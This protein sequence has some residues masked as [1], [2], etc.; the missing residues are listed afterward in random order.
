MKKIIYT[1][2]FFLIN[3]TIIKSQTLTSTYPFPDYA[4][5]NSFWGITKINDTLRIATDNNGSIYKVTTAG[6]IR[7]SLTT[8]FTFNHGLV[9][10]GTGYWIA[11]DFRSAGARLLK[12]NSAGIRI[13]SIQLP[14]LIGGATGGVGDIALDASGNGIWFSV[15]SPDFT[16]YPFAY[17]YKINLTSRIITDTIPLRG[18]QVQGITVKGD[19][20]LYVSDSFQGDAERIYAYRKAVGDTLF[21]FPVPDPDGVCKPRGMHW[22]GQN[23]WLVADRIG[24]NMFIYKALYKYSLTGLGNPQITTNVNSLDFGNT[25]IG[26]S[27]DRTLTISNTGTAKLIIS[28][29]NITNPRFT[30]LP[31]NVPDTINIGQTKNYTVT[32]APTVFDTTSGQL[33]IT[34]NDGGT[35]VKIISLKGKGVNNGSN[36]LLSA[37]SYDFGDRNSRSTCGWIFSITNT[38]SQILNIHLMETYTNVFKIDTVGLTFPV[39]IDTQKTKEFRIWFRPPHSASTTNIDSLRIFSNAVNLPIAK[40]YLAGNGLLNFNILFGN[41]VWQGTI[42]DNPFTSSDYYKPVSIKQM[43]DINGDQVNEIV[44]AS[45]NYLTTCFNG[46]SSV[47]SDVLWSFNTGTSN[48]NSGSVTYED[49]MQIRSDIDGDGFQDV[50]IGCG[51]GNEMVYT[52]SGRTGK[53]IWA[54]GDSVTFSDGDVNGVRADKDYNNDGIA[55]VIF[56]ASGESSGM[57]RRS[58]ICV[59]GLNGNLIFNSPQSSLFL[60]DV[61]NTQIGGAISHSNSGAPYYAQGFNNTGNNLWQYSS[62]DIIWGMRNIPS[63]NSDTINEIICQAG[64]SGRVTAL[65]GLTGT[66]I[67]ERTLGASINGNVKYFPTTQIFGNHIDKFMIVSGQKTLNKL[68]P[69][70]GS[71]MWTN[72]L[73]N[74]Y[75]LGSDV[76]GYSNNA[77]NFDVAAGTLGNNFYILNGNTG[78]V[79]FQYSFG[80]G[81]TN[82]AVEKV[83]ILG[84]A[85]SYN[86]NANEIVAGSRDGRIICFTGGYYLTPAVTNISTNIPHKFSLSQNYPNPFNPNTKIKFDLTSDA[87]RETQ[88]V[89]LIIYDA[90][91][92]EVTKLVN[93]KL[94][95]GTYEAEFNAANFPSGIY[96]YKLETESFAATKRMI[97]LK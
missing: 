50:V 79:K 94:S 59:N 13:D 92:K 88:D 29:Y 19:T 64:F 12:I 95:A 91:G 74:T 83:A 75:I 45:A 68:N 70:T 33:R 37:N 31:N 17:A 65:N 69:E 16:S 6:V 49:A 66:S 24:N 28:N 87:R 43:N 15:Y 20:I 48:I 5:Y 7:D 22:D 54:Y 76:I 8:P 81:N 89:K 26:T 60:Y 42:P 78:A 96:F 21:S 41:I 53:R 55:D 35:P 85:T 36:I 90:V 30:M 67:W 32:F 93:E 77:V 38:G 9:W 2:I 82:F 51:G 97:L 27:S 72:N 57:G 34:S 18:K 80:N 63:I 10:D 71:D 40:I 62:P 86:G 44:V 4:Q 61:V 25:I 23:L 14:G 52:L 56:S 3:V 11:E 58:L 84:E 1:I 39:S 46:N 47:T 73:D